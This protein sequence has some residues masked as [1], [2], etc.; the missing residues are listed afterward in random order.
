MEG[1]DLKAGNS[2]DEP[3]KVV[4]VNKSV[5]GSIVLAGGSWNYL[6]FRKQA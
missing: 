2:I 1:A 5:D 6:K 3:E 4:P